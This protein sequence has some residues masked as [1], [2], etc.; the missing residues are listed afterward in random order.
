LIFTS[1]I[2]GLVGEFFSAEF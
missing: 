1:K 2:D